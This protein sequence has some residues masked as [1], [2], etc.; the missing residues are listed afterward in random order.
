MPTNGTSSS[1]FLPKHSRQQNSNT[2]PPKQVKVKP[3]LT[4]TPA[5]T[6]TALLP[7]N[8][9]LK[10]APPHGEKGRNKRTADVLAL[11]S[12]KEMGAGGTIRLRKDSG[13]RKKPRMGGQGSWKERAGDLEK[14]G[15]RSSRYHTLYFRAC[16]G[17]DILSWSIYTRASG[18]RLLG[19]FS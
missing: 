19:L 13:A 5:T 18:A 8:A 4:H 14:Q 2:K 7:Q 6:A 12:E 10:D 3:S 11:F 17:V 15:K 9:G 16:S 1:P